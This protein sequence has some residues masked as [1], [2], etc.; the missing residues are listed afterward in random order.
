MR[1]R[2]SSSRDST[3][4]AN[5]GMSVVRCRRTSVCGATDK[6]DAVVVEEPLELRVSGVA[7]ATLMRTPGSDLELALGFFLT[8]GWISSLSDVGSI[9]LC[10]RTGTEARPRPG[11]HSNEENVVSLIPAEG[12]RQLRSTAEAPRLQPATA[13]CGVCGKRTIEEVLALSPFAPSA[14]RKEP[15]GG[16]GLFP[17]TPAAV[18]SPRVLLSL[19]QKLLAEQRIF[20]ATGA[21]H[22]A[23]IFDASGEL[24]AAAEDVGRH[25]AVDKVIGRS[26]LAGL[27]PLSRHTLHVSGRVSFEIVQK[28]YR[29]GIPMVA[30]VSG[31]S[32]LAVEL[33]ERSGITLA[34]FVRGDAFNLYA[35]GE[36]VRE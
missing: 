36:R 6:R 7:V 25:N 9:A 4:E 23:A 17:G 27:A 14:G 10:A 19:P 13:S 18:F 30:A 8:E 21:L 5:R 26:L 35:H 1:E 31:V 20:H 34:G 24:L 22:A 15:A 29:A 3:G 33:A 28:A 2:H 11:E 12:A 16:G 32:S